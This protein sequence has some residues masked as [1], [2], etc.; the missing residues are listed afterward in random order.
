MV[1]LVYLPAGPGANCSWCITYS[2]VFIFSQRPNCDTR[3]AFERSSIL[4][5]L[6]S[7]TDR[8][9]KV[10][11]QL[12]SQKA[13]SSREFKGPIDCAK[14]IIRVQGIG[15]LWSGFVGSL[16]FRSNFFWMFLSFEVWKMQIFYLTID[17]PTLKGAHAEFFAIGRHAVWGILESH[18]IA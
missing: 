2:Q 5:R 6:P 3:R 18:V 17:W 4:P 12:Q 10:K 16:A 15:G 11:L 13:I 1:L 8:P 14:Q 9:V 7:C